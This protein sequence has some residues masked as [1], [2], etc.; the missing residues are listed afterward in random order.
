MVRS[1]CHAKSFRRWSR[2]CGA[3]LTDLHAHIST[4]SRARAGQNLKSS[5]NTEADSPIIRCTL[6]SASPPLKGSRCEDPVTFAQAGTV[7]RPNNKRHGLREESTR[8]KLEWTYNYLTLCV[9]CASL[10]YYWFARAQERINF[11]NRCSWQSV[12]VRRE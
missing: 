10:I 11:G 3:S 12:A 5:M 6:R 2:L 4:V 1:S 7:T 8:A 9:C